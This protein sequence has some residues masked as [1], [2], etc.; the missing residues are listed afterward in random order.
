[1]NMDI[2][3]AVDALTTNDATPVNRVLFEATPNSGINARL[4][5]VARRVSDGAQKSWDLTAAMRKQ[6]AGVAENLATRD[7]AAFGAAGDLTA[8][9]AVAIAF[10][11]SGNNIGITVTG[12]AGTAINWGVML[13]GIQLI[14]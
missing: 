8:L 14:D 4:L 11:A 2:I 5:I 3:D 7:A 12:L 10:F 6:G 9:A 1:M 13:R